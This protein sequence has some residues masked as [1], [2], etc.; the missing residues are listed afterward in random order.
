MDISKLKIGPRFRRDVGDIRSLASSIA[1]I[2]LLHPVVADEHG[3]LIAGA[4]RL[5][6]VKALGWR[7]VPVRVVR[8]LSDAGRALRAE[9]DEERSPQLD[10]GH[11]FTLYPL[12]ESLGFV[13]IGELRG[14]LGG[15]FLDAL[16]SGVEF[17]RILRGHLTESSCNVGAARNGLVHG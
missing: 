6:A 5:A 13:R 8:S 12:G 7:D 15:E 11:D 14:Q 17:D 16:Q 10:C 2:G 1:T 4:R 9:R 3:H